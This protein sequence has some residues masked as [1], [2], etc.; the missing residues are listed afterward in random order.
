MAIFGSSPSGSSLLEVPHAP[1]DGLLAVCTSRRGRSLVLIRTCQT[2]TADPRASSATSGSYDVRLVL[3]IVT[4][5]V[6]DLPA[7]RCDSRIRDDD[8]NCRHTTIPLPCLSTATAGFSARP[9]YFRADRFSP[10]RP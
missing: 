2:A 1:P 5:L 9:G 8:R 10:A 4:G 6:H 7:G 3:E